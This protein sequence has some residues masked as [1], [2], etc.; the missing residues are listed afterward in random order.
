MVVVAAS[1]HMPELVMHL[2]ANHQCPTESKEPANKEHLYVL[3]W[4]IMGVQR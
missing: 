3:N 2:Q 1:D 4:A